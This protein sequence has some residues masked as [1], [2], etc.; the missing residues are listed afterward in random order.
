MN[1][2]FFS[3]LLTALLV[4][5]T[6]IFQ[7]CNTPEKSD[8]SFQAHPSPY[9][10]YGAQ[11]PRI[12]AD[13]RVSFRF[14]APDAK[15]VQVSIYNVPYD[16]IRDTAGVWTYTSE[17]QDAGYHNYWMIVDSAIMLDPATDLF[18]GYSKCVNGFEV[19]ILKVIFMS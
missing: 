4:T 19:L 5:G 18:I 15:K 16:M 14:Y 10:L 12:E 17:P 11:Y 6:L 9:N 2:T 3:I 1:K 8:F 7:S 13:S